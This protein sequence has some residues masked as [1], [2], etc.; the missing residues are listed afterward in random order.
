[1]YSDEFLAGFTLRDSPA[2]DE[3]QFFQAEQ[4]RQSLAQ[5]LVRLIHTHET[6]GAFEPA[7]LYARRWLAL[8][9]MHEPAHRKLMQL[10]NGSG[11]QAAALRQY[12]QCVKVLDEE[13]HLPPQPETSELERIRLGREPGPTV[14]TVERPTTRYVQ[15]GDVHIAYQ[16]LGH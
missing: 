16:V 5:V 8:D 11:Q 15:S 9:P 6:S 4:L 14:K 10:Y 13:L 7:I 2:F 12:Q 3:W 1:L